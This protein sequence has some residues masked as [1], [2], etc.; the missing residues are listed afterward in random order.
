MSG[1]T[2]RRVAS[3]IRLQPDAIEAYEAL[4]TDVWPAVLRQI[5]SS[6]IRNYSIFRYGNQL[7]SYFEYV[8]DDYE[9]DM[10]AMAA[11]PE[12]QRW[13]QLCEPMQQPVA[14]RVATEWW[15]VVPEVFH[16]D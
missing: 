2:L 5:R 8:G 6:G 9:A 12:T 1:D 7:I 14:E 3:V 4:H 10:R 11:D 13:W 16:A 15:H